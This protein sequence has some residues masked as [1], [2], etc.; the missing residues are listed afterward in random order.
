MTDATPHP[1]HLDERD[2]AKA[3]VRDVREE[4]DR[5]LEHYQ[6]QGREDLVL[7]VPEDRWDE[8]LRLTGGEASGEETTYRGAR[9]RKAAVTAVIAQDGF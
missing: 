7:L 5:E 1:A 4:A 8:F 9:F 6:A 3:D 2:P